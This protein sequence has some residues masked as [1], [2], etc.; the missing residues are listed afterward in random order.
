[1]SIIEIFPNY[2]DFK[3]N[4][5]YGYSYENTLI[6]LSLLKIPGLKLINDPQMYREKGRKFRGLKIIYFPSY[7]FKTTNDMVAQIVNKKRNGD[8]TVLPEND[9]E[10]TIII[11]KD[12]YKIKYSKRNLVL[13]ECNNQYDE[14]YKYLY[15]IPKESSNMIIEVYDPFYKFNYYF[16]IKKLNSY[17]GSNDQK[18]K[19]IY[20]GVFKNYVIFFYKSKCENDG[21]FLVTKEF[22]INIYNSKIISSFN[23]EN[24]K[25]LDI[26][27]KDSFLIY[28]SKSNKDFNKLTEQILYREKFV[29]GFL[30]YFNEKYK[31]KN[32]FSYLG[33]FIYQGNIE[34][35]YYNEKI[36]KR[37]NINYSILQNNMS[38]FGDKILFEK[39]EITSIN[40]VKIDIKNIN[41]NAEAMRKEIEEIKKEIKNTNNTIAEVKTELNNKI[42]VVNNTIAEVKTE[43]N[44][45]ITEVKTELNNKITVVNNKITEVQTELS[46][47]KN[48]VSDIKKNIGFIMKFISSLQ[49]KF[50]LNDIENELKDDKESHQQN[51]NNRNNNFNNVSQN[52]SLFDSRQTITQINT[53][54]PGKKDIIKVNS[55]NNNT[56]DTNL[57]NKN[58]N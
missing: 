45:K 2:A 53:N 14:K 7:N 4:E 5:N 58:I 32:D 16:N 6:N 56:T 22:N 10:S 40:E 34:L 24:Q 27:K 12:Q 38:L 39:E 20:I 29:E 8:F 47:V 35:P 41:G 28:E 55:D 9:V 30:A 36:F 46:G 48:D 52:N 21:L 44:N 25:A 1:M 33:F 31:I 15:Y 54:L 26:I 18:D 42:T 19:L 37:N 49:S 23:K 17:Q 57:I 11:D 51:S 13:S 50:Q 3:S 43:L